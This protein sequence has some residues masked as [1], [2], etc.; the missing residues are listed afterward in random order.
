MLPKESIVKIV[1][2]YYTETGLS[3]IYT[4]RAPGIRKG[5]QRIVLL[6]P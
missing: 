2:M 1:A 4:P 5:D 6:T 3:H